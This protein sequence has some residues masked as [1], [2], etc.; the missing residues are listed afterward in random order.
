MKI[1]NRKLADFWERNG[2]DY[3]ASIGQMYRAITLA[4][5]PDG[6]GISERSY[7]PFKGHYEKRFDNVYDASVYSIGVIKDWVQSIFVLEKEN[8]KELVQSYNNS[9]D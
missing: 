8:Q 3:H 7:F 1:D 2:G 5:Y 9:I 4:K 6:W